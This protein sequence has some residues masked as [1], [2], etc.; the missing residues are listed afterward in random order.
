MPYSVLSLFPSQIFRR[1]PLVQTF[2]AKNTPWHVH[3]DKS[4]PSHSISVSKKEVKFGQIFF[5]EK[6]L[7]ETDNWK[8]DFLINT[9]L[10]SS[11]LGPAVI[12]HIYPHKLKFWS[13]AGIS[14][15]KPLSGEDHWSCTKFNLIIPLFSLDISTKRSNSELNKDQLPWINGNL[16]Y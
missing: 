4:S 12:F 13:R 8:D 14:F 9:M 1:V 3:G 11:C 10:I 15:S 2:T 7:Y 16:K 6:L 5:Q